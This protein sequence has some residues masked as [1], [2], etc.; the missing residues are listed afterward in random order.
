MDL[1][2]SVCEV[3]GGSK[4]RI[5]EGK[6]DGKPEVVVIENVEGRVGFE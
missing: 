1:D 5:V 2:G 6:E 3:E 4:R